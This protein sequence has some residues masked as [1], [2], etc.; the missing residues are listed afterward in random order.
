MRPDQATTPGRGALRQPRLDDGRDPHPN[1]P[2]RRGPPG[3][4]VRCLLARAARAA[5]PRPPETGA[6]AMARLLKTAVRAFGAPKY[7]ITDL[8]PEFIGTIFRRTAARLGILQRFASRENHHATARLERFWRTLKDTA[9]LRL[10]APLTIHDLER[11]L[12]LALARY[13]GH[14]PHQ[15]LNGATPAESFLGLPPAHQRAAS[16]PRGRP[17]EGPDRPPFT[18]DFLDP[19]QRSFPILK[20]AQAR[21][22]IIRTRSRRRAHVC[23]LLRVPHHRPGA[24]L[25]SPP[26]TQPLHALDWRSCA[27]SNSHCRPT[28]GSAGPARAAVRHQRAT[29]EASAPLHPSAAKRSSG[30]APTTPAGPST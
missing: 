26:R 14:R 2:R 13:L 11:R 21:S 24:R 12:E 23:A 25:Q 17:G 3:W 4:S 20:A 16:P 22:Q 5:V 8:G 18:I 27:A 15:G 19:N 6:S 9:S 29:R 30:A 10:Q 1:L 28:R 7:L